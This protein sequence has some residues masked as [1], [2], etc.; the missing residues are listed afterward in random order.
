[1]AFLSLF[2]ALSVRHLVLKN[3][4]V[5]PP[6]VTLM[7]VTTER[8][9]AWY[10]ERAK[11]GVGTIIVEAVKVELFQSGE[12]EEA[13]KKLA[14][15]IHA[16]GATAAIQLFH[17]NVFNGEQV[18]ASAAGKARTVTRE[19]IGQ[20]IPRYARAAEMAVRAGFDAVE[21][22]GAHGFFMNQFFSPRTN[23]RDDEYG[24]SL[25]CR[26]RFGLDVVKAVRAA[27]GKAV[28]FYRHTPE[29]LGKAGYSLSDSQQFAAKLVEAGVDVLDISPSTRQGEGQEHAALAAAIKSVVKCPVIAVGGMEDPK[30][31]TTV[32]QG[33]QADLVAVGRQLIADAHWANKV[34]ADKLGAVIACKKCNQKCFGHLGKGIPIGCAENPKSGFEYLG[35]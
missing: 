19:E 8:A 20:I 7:G 21:P 10:A 23:K 29:Q 11:G 9:R 16:N 15:A 28:M 17:A 5:M 31:A 18:A 2:D 1:M 35:T 14:A 32:L 25:E 30:A 6:M 24:G 33:D 12:F 3:R 34:A 27:I 4:I 26:M 22:H 13:L